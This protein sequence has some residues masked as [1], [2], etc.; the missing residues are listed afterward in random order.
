MARGEV[1]F[2]WHILY[3]PLFALRL[4]LHVSALLSRSRCT[5]T[6]RAM[7]WFKML[8]FP[9]GGDPLSRDAAAARARRLRARR[10]S[11]T[12]SPR[13]ACFE[14]F[15]LRPARSRAPHQRPVDARHDVLRTDPA[16]LADAADP[17]VA[18][19]ASGG[20]S[21]RGRSL[22]AALLLTFTR[23]VWLGWIAAAF[24]V[25][26]ADAGPARVLRA[27]GADPL[28]HLPAARPLQPADL[29]IRHETGVELR[30]H[31]HAR[32]RRRR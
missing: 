17:L 14:F 31:A 22:T 25:L 15:V 18:R 19:A 23:S 3:F 24:V 2:S 6:A 26:L 21:P 1:R 16:A 32:G 13:G 7:L 11:P 12:T 27:A 8:I 20:S 4:R 29:D 5:H 30:S 9:C 10:R 28:H